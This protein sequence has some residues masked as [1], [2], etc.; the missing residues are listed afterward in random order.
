MSDLKIWSNGYDFLIAESEDAAKELLK[1]TTGFQGDEFLEGDGWYAFND[2][3]DFT[4]REEDDKP[5]KQTAKA[6]C[7]EHGVGYF[8]AIDW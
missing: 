6:W 7:E 8:A 4:L 1:K 5:R 2:N 3:D